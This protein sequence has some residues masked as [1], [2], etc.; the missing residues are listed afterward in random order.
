[1]SSVSANAWNLMRDRDET[2]SLL[3]SLPMVPAAPIERRG[4]SPYSETKKMV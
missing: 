4:L 1:M 3:P 2:I